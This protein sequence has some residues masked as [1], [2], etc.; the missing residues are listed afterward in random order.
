[1]K[2]AYSFFGVAL[3]NQNW[4]QLLLD[5]C[6]NSKNHIRLTTNILRNMFEYALDYAFVNLVIRNHREST[7]AES[8]LRKCLLVENATI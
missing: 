6:T 8:I 5:D 2:N 4:R 3:V 7:E 1:M